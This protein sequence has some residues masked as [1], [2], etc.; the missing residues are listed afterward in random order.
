[1]RSTPRHLTG[2]LAAAFVL[3][4]FAVPARAQNRERLEVS[5]AWYRGFE[6]FQSL[7]ADTL[8]LKYSTSYVPSL[9]VDF[10]VLDL[11]L[12]KVHP[13]SLHVGSGVFLDQRILGPAFPG[14]RTGEFPVLGVQ[15]AVFL[16]VPLDLLK[17]NTGVSFRIGWDGDELLTRSGPNDFLTSTM[18][19]F[20]FTRTTGGMQGSSILIGKGR[21][22]AYGRD[23]AS[24]RWDARLSLQGR[25]IGPP[26]PP[27]PAA[28]PGAKP[29]PRPAAPDERIVWFVIEAGM[30]TDGSIG[31]DGLYGRVGLAMDLGH[32]ALGMFASPLH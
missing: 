17:G 6:R 7:E 9:D 20:G 13:P 24:G 26:A 29:P 23:A 19:R 8:G 2:L 28:K 21:D 14:S 30:N 4:C 1:M 31:P 32:W 18:L 22:E 16:D 27:A 12:A 11:P 15:G 10:R 3:A 5:A 25:L